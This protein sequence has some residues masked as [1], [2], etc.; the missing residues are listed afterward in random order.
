MII[1]GTLKIPIIFNMESNTF[2]YKKHLKYKY[3][4]YVNK[5]D[6]IL[7]NNKLILNWDIWPQEI[8]FKTSYNIYTIKNKQCLDKCITFFSNHY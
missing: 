4:N 1:D 3:F 8:Y 7:D 2:E 5:G 6:F